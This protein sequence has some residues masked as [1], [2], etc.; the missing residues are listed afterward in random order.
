MSTLDNLDEIAKVLRYVLIIATTKYDEEDPEIVIAKDY[1]LN[2][3]QTSYEHEENLKEVYK[4][5]T[6]ITLTWGFFF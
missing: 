4:G 1:L 5:A 3:F 2:I 6:L